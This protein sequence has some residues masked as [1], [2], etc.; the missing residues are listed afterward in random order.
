MQREKPNGVLPLSFFQDEE[1]GTSDTLVHEDN[2]VSACDFPAR[3]KTKTPN[4][5][6]SISDLI[7]SLYSQVDE[8]VSV[9]S[10]TESSLVNGEDNS[11]EFQGPSLASKNSDDEFDDDSWEFQGP[12]QAVK[13]SLKG[14]NVWDQSQ[15][16][17]VISIEP[18][19]YKDFFHKLKTELYYIALSHL[20]SLMVSR[21]F[22]FWIFLSL[23]I[24]YFSFHH[25]NFF[26]IEGSS[27]LGS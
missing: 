26:Y 21:V 12:T 17:P 8:K 11:W 9:K 3:A 23:Y 14:E 19:D 2:P 4:P 22:V 20:E 10:A 24:F 16:K 18:N 27:W 13:D 1:L 25:L 15:E 5:N 6:V 7:S